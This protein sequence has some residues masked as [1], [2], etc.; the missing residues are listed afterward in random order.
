MKLRK[1]VRE[2]ISRTETHMKHFTFCFIDEFGDNF[3][4][5]AVWEVA[6]EFCRNG[7]KL[8]NLD[9]NQ[10]GVR[11]AQMRGFDNCHI[12]IGDGV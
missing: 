8:A 4:T 5:L 3:I 6:R 10:L 2:F 11:F 7:G 1:T 12:E 9:V